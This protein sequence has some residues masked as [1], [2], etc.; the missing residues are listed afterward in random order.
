MKNHLALL[1]LLVPLGALAQGSVVRSLNGV[2]TNQTLFDASGVESAQMDGRQL[3]DSSGTQSAQWST[4]ALN[5]T[6]GT[7]SVAWGTRLLE[8]SGVANSVDWQHRLLSDTAGAT[9]LDWHNPATIVAQHPV[10]VTNLTQPWGAVVNTGSNAF[11]L[12]SNNVLVTYIPT[13]AAPHWAHGVSLAYKATNIAVVLTGTS[14]NIIF[15]AGL[16]SR[17]IPANS[18]LTGSTIL[19]QFAGQVSNTASLTRSNWL[20]I[21]GTPVAILTAAG[22]SGQQPSGAGLLG[23]HVDVTAQGASGKVNWDCQMET[24]NQATAFSQTNAFPLDTTVAH[25]FDIVE[26]FSNTGNTS[27][28]NRAEIYVIN[29]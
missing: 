22:T 25:T 27:F 24:F 26:A 8:D 10:A 6:S 12:Y 2:S 1:F 28:Y 23:W 5:D 15:G 16:G 29:P 4:R 20:V 18:L 9:A 21:D 13:N 19:F 7:A 3:F 14:T 11:G 17:V